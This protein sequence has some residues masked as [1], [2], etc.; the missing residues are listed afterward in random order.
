MLCRTSVW[1]LEISWLENKPS[2]GDQ[3]NNKPGLFTK[4]KCTQQFILGI[5][6]DEEVMKKLKRKRSLEEIKQGL[7]VNKKPALTP[8][9]DMLIYSVKK[10]QRLQKYRKHVKL[11]LK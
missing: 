6:T 9:N 10:Q 3:L 7:T 4:H 5:E 11:D 2:I 8:R 1:R